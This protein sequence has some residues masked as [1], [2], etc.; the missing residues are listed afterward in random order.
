M[1]IIGKVIKKVKNYLK[2]RRSSLIFF[3]ID[4]NHEYNYNSNLEFMRINNFIELYDYC[5]NKVSNV[6]HLINK[7]CENRFDTGSYIVLAIKDHFCVS[8]GWVSDNGIFWISEID[9]VIKSNN[10][11]TSILYDFMT[12]KDYRGN[13]YYSELLIWMTNN[14]KSNNCIIYSYD[15]NHSSIRGI[16]KASGKIITIL[17]HFKNNQ[18]DFFKLYG[19]SK[20]GSKLKMFGIRRKKY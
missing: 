13:G 6:N 20:I 18:C 17:T 2:T 16:K 12:M 19:Y 15:Y 11:K 9:I 7:E 8:Y 5:N 10:F 14:C 4:K 1:N 3:Q